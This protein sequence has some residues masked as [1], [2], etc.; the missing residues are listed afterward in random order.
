MVLLILVGVGVIFARFNIA[1]L[2]WF[3]RA[4]SHFL[5]LTSLFHLHHYVFSLP[6]ILVCSR[7]FE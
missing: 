3:L 1:A 5:R 7:L 6:F 4:R 2:G